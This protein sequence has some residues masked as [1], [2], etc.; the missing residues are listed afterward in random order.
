[1][2]CLFEDPPLCDFF[3]WLF[4]SLPFKNYFLTFPLEHRG[5]KLRLELAIDIQLSIPI[6]EGDEDI[7]QVLNRVLGIDSLQELS[8]INLI[9]EV[10]GDKPDID[11]EIQILLRLNHTISVLSVVDVLC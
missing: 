8:K 2:H 11:V 5:L 7:R 1:M 9:L 3:E 6:V 10:L 4:D